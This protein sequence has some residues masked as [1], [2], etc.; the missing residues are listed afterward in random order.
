MPIAEFCEREYETNFNGQI[1]KLHEYVWTPGQP[2]EHFLGFDAAFLS[3]TRLIFD[4]FPAWRLNTTGIRLSPDA[5]QEYFKIADHHFSSCCFNL[6]VQHK[7]PEYIG[8]L[9]GKERSHWKHPYFRYDI[10]SNQQAGLEKLEMVAGSNALVTYA[11]AAFHTRRELLEHAIKTTL[12]ESS[13]FVRPGDLVA[14]NRY[15]FDMPGSTGWATSEPEVVE[16]QEFVKRFR[17]CLDASDPLPLSEIIRQTGEIVQETIG[18]SV[19]PDQLFEQIMSDIIQEEI[20]ETSVLHSY[21]MVQV[22]CYLNQTSWS[23][24]A[25]SP[26]ESGD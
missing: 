6:F 25:Q 2:Q 15:S 16:G 5:W 21:V 18:W 22:F 19:V 13:N 4:L 24:I 7:R 11:C 17:G 9:M 23:I 26:Q 14:H 8:S 20:D 1:T 10:D 3:D 12:I